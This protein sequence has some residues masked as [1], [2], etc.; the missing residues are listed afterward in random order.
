MQ[1][2][3][4]WYFT[5][6]IGWWHGFKRSLLAPPGGHRKWCLNPLCSTPIF[7]KS[8]RFFCLFWQEC[9]HVRL[10]LNLHHF[11][12]GPWLLVSSLILLSLVIFGCRTRQWVKVWGPLWF[13]CPSFQM[14]CPCSRQ[15]CLP[16]FYF[17][18]LVYLGVK[19]CS[20]HNS[21]EGLRC[22]PI[23]T[24]HPVSVITFCE[25]KSLL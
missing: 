10:L 22:R 25:H 14:L 16:L 11:S 12:V 3:T 7:G 9:S 13:N 24:I 20:K 19:L 15:F 18:F 6:C 17:F 8:R 2:F 1:F 23:F 5:L 21:A 4:A